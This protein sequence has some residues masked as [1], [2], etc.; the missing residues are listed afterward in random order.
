MS[1][2]VILMYHRISG[3]GSPFEAKYACPPT[4]FAGHMK[5]LRHHDYRLIGLGEA[6]AY[7]DN[8]SALPERAVVITLDDGYRDNFENAFRILQRYCVPATLFI[9]TNSVG[10]MSGWTRTPW[11]ML[12]WNQIEKMARGG[13]D[14]GSHSVGH[15]RL[16]GLSQPEAWD[17]IADAKQVLESR[18]CKQVRHFAYPFGAHA[19]E[20]R[21][22]VRDAGYRLGLSTTAGRNNRNVDRFALRRVPIHGTDSLD[23]LW[24]KLATAFGNPHGRIGGS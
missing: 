10:R 13:I 21:A 11:P 1:G 24:R 22:L 4:V 5:W 15:L 8:A 2:F 23:R 19:P 16:T 12:T 9:T 7:M 17:E 18:L 14:V 20:V 6:E 3:F